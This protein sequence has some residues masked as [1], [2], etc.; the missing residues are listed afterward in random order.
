MMTLTT[1]TRYRYF[2]AVTWQSDKT[3]PSDATIIYISMQ[4]R[5]IFCC[6]SQL[7]AMNSRTMSTR[8]CQ[9]DPQPLQSRDERTEI[10]FLFLILW[11][12]ARISA[13]RE[14]DRL[15]EKE[16]ENSEGADRQ[17][18]PTAKWLARL[19]RVSGYLKPEEGDAAR[20]L[21]D[22]VLCRCHLTVRQN[23][24]QR[25]HYISSVSRS[26]VAAVT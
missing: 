19:Q 2:A 17:R 22:S 24:S 9:T 4:R 16:G 18:F 12:C 6:S 23:K 3:N 1:V 11:K 26:F 10:Q 13:S 14:R 20:L 8:R 7:I 5:S 21:T 25:C 15:E